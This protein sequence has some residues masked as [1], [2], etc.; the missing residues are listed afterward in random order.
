VHLLFLTCLL[1]QAERAAV[2]VEQVLLAV[3]V[4]VVVI[5]LLPLLL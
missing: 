4:A 2:V 1:W 5:A 3:A